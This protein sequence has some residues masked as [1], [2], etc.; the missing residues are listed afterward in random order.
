MST[1]P[2]K[3]AFVGAADDE[4]FFVAAEADSDKA[5]TRIN[6]ESESKMIFFDKTNFLLCFLKLLKVRV[7]FYHIE[8]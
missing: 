5:K 2:T 3:S 6:T 4:D 1:M 8:L 7:A